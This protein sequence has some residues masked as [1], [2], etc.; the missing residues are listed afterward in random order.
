MNYLQLFLFI[1]TSIATLAWLL[2]IVRFSRSIS[3]LLTLDSYKDDA[4]ESVTAIIPVR[5]DNPEK[6][7]ESLASDNSVREIIIVDDE[8]DEKFKILL[9]KLKERY[10]DLRIINSN[11]KGKAVACQ[12]GADAANSELLL[13]LDADTVLHGNAVARSVNLLL[14]NGLDAISA[15]GELRCKS[16]DKIMTPFSFGLLNA[17]IPLNDV[18]KPGKTGFFFGSFILFRKASYY[19]IG[20]HSAVSDKIL[21]D[22]ALGE[23][24]KKKG[25]RIAI[26]NGKNYVSA[27]WAPGFK[28]N[29]NALRRV[30]APSMSGKAIQSLLVTA[31]MS[32][33]LITPILAAIAGLANMYLLIL[34]IFSLLLQLLFSIMASNSINVNRLYALAFP[35]AA[36]VLAATFWASFLVSYRHGKI[37]WRGREYRL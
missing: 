25:L 14:D 2:L 20:G 26:A 1:V 5:N 3:S 27:E 36:I 6:C 7:V 11:G 22:K 30:I 28:E 23:I 37:S 9:L 35:S 4:S 24:A 32:F 8:S 16:F 10:P 29:L 17:L 12:Q 13:F 31:A 34:G 18:M 15:I 21:E 19:M 33:L